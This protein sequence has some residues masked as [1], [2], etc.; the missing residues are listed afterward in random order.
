MKELSLNILDIAQNSVSAKAK[1]ICISV[2]EN[3]KEN[4]LNTTITDDGCGM[5]HDDAKICFQRH[6]TSKIK[7]END[8]YFINS[9]GFSKSFVSFILFMLS[10][11]IPAFI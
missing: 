9:L 8:L 7:N 3:Q 6:A 4:L 1:L 5:S 2:F 10:K 11:S